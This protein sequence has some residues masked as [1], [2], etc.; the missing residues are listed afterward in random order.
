MTTEFIYNESMNEYIMY[1]EK[2]EIHVQENELSEKMK[3]RA[4]TILKKYS[5]K[6]AIISEFCLESATFKKCYPN[7][8]KEE[9]QVK[10]GIPIISIDKQGG[11]L[12]YVNQTIDD[13]HI[14]DI[15]FIGDLEELFSVNIDG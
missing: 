14:I 5:S 11:I 1:Q 10:L 9:V 4:R 3:E 6:L 15:E 7:V 12:T 2:F 13:N 8:S